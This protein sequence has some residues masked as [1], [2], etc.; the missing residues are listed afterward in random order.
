MYLDS[1]T[2]EDRWACSCL[3]FT[4]ALVEAST[5]GPGNE[6]ERMGAHGATKRALEF[7][8]KQTNKIEKYK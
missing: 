6:K 3:V 4:S 2:S 7:Y 1:P 8:L 5:M